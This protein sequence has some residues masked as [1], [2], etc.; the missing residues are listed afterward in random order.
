MK[1]LVN[2]SLGTIT[3]IV[4][5]LLHKVISRILILPYDNSIFYWGS[6]IIIFIILLSLINIIIDIKL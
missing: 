2:I 6:F 5:I 4:T 3:L 1:K